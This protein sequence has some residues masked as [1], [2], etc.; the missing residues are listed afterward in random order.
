MKTSQSQKHIIAAKTIFSFFLKSNAFPFDC[1]PC[2]CVWWWW[3]REHLKCLF[4]VWVN[5]SE[6]DV[7]V[8]SR[9]I[10]SVLRHYCRRVH[11]CA[12]VCVWAPNHSYRIVSSHFLRLCR[13]Y[14]DAVANPYFANGINKQ[15]Q[16]TRTLCTQKSISIVIFD[17]ITVAVVVCALRICVFLFVRWKCV[18]EYATMTTSHTDTHHGQALSFD[19]VVQK[20]SKMLSHVYRFYD[21]IKYV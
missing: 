14:A 15:R 10:V 2:V 3:C 11:T 13:Q 21:K 18:F 5:T 9:N 20:V 12:R 16:P 7:A 17:S 6:H 4:F 19:T 8:K 1:S